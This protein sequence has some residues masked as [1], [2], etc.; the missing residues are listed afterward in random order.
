[1]FLLDPE[2]VEIGLGSLDDAPFELQPEAELWIR[3]RESWIS[4]VDGAAQYDEN[5]N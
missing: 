2:G 3:R 5:R 1:L 4:P